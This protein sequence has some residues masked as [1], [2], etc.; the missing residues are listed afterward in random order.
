MLDFPG[1][2]GLTVGQVFTSAGKSWQWDGAKWAAAAGGGAPLDSPSFTGDPKAPTPA[3]ADN[4]TSIATTA[5]VKA[6]GYLLNN[7]VI[8]LSGDITG[9]GATAIAATLA[10]VPVAKGGTG[11]TTAP[12]AVTNLGAVAKAGD[13]MTGGLTVN[14]N[15]AAPPAS[16]GLGR[17]VISELQGP[18]AASSAELVSAYGGAPTYT[19]RRANGTAAART[20][21]LNGQSLGVFEAYGYGATGFGWNAGVT[22]SAIATENYTDTAQGALIGFNTTANGT[23]ASARCL[24]LGQGLMVGAV[25]DPGAGSIRTAGPI[26]LGGNIIFFAGA[27]SAGPYVSGDNANI[28]W[29]LGPSN[30]YYAWYDSTN[31]VLAMYLGPAGDLLV[32]SS[33]AQK[34]GGGPWNAPSDMR[35]KTTIEPYQAGLAELQQLQ[36]ITYEYNGE[37]GMPTGER[38]CGLVADDVKLVMPET[39]GTTRLGI[40]P[41]TSDPGQEYLTFNQGPLTFALINST[42]EIADLINKLTERVAALEAGR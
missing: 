4:D 18:N 11:A 9:S 23:N 13:T 34:P 3:T 6:Q 35:L 33:N 14:L 12:T 22:I 26:Y 5:Y 41:A 29:R 8:T 19:L 38:F 16:T 15:A 20:A 27:T 40:N 32:N 37:A 31:S 28:Q 36:P 30:G 7:Q 17:T 1:P 39:V 24:T 10:T 21:I 2:G 25:A 42:K